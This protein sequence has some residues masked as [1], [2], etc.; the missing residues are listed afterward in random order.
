[1]SDIVA[2]IRARLD[3][4]ERLATDNGTLQGERWTALEVSPAR[5]TWEVVGVGRV[6]AE[7]LEWEA[8]HIARQDPARTLREVDAKRR[9]LF[10]AEHMAASV[11][12]IAGVADGGGVWMHILRLMAAPYSDHPDYDQSWSVTA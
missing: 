2:F 9:L 8:R 5:V 12:R 4:D 7:A 6:V 1:M 10:H 3:E 11:A